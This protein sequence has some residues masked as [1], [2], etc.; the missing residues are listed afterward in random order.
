MA[1]TYI[2]V[3]YCRTEHEALSFVHQLLRPRGQALGCQVLVAPANLA[4]GMTD[5]PSVLY[6][7]GWCPDTLPARA[8]G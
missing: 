4:G 3:P 6:R 7:F 5:A 8:A 1:A 2:S